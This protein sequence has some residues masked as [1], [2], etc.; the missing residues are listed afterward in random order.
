MNAVKMVDNYLPGFE[1][2]N[3]METAPQKKIEEQIDAVCRDI[4]TRKKNTPSVGT[5]QKIGMV[6]VRSV[7]RAEP[8][9]SA[10]PEQVVAHYAPAVRLVMGERR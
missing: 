9:A 1:M 7:I 3:Q 10:D 5:V 8:L 4:A 6:L 2:K